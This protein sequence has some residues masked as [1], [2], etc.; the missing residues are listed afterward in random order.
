M[1]KFLGSFSIFS[2]HLV[3]QRWIY[4]F[5]YFYVRY[6]TKTE[7]VQWNP[8][9]QGIWILTL[10]R[11]YEHLQSCWYKNSSLGMIILAIMTLFVLLRKVTLRTDFLL[12]FSLSKYWD[13]KVNDEN[14]WRVLRYSIVEDK[15]SLLDWWCK[16]MVHIWA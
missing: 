2:W 15:I 3:L 12:N 11:G 8:Q 16:S 5:I 14:I 9:Y 6:T 1:L 7:I 13:R 10:S 4:I